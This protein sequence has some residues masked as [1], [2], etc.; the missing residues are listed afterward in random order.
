MEDVDRATEPLVDVVRG[1]RDGGTGPAAQPGRPG[2]IAEWG[3]LPAFSDPRMSVA[4]DGVPQPGSVSQDLFFGE[5]P[6]AA[7]LHPMPE[8]VYPHVFAHTFHTSGCLSASKIGKRQ[9]SMFSD[10]APRLSRTQLACA[11][12]E[13]HKQ[14]PTIGRRDNSMIANPQENSWG[15]AYGVETVPTIA[16]AKNTGETSDR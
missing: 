11:S 7:A 6:G 14:Q 12:N 13:L 16:F 5:S 4:P 3:P 8:P 9:K 10:L 15:V 1:A 2:E